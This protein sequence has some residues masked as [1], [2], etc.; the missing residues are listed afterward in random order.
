MSRNLSIQSSHRILVPVDMSDFPLASGFPH[1]FRH[2]L[3][4]FFCAESSMWVPLTKPRELLKQML[5]TW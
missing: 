5:I 4:H 2:E 1:R 3:S